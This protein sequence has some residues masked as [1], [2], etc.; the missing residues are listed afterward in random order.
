MTKEYTPYDSIYMKY[1]EEANL[2]TESKL[3]IAW[4][5]RGWEFME[6]VC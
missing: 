3:V 6:T 4:D 1:L 5:Q 2:E